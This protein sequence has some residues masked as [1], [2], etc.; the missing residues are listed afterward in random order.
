MGVIPACVLLL[1]V[2]GQL[3]VISE[4]MANPPIET[5]GEYV[6]IHNPSSFPC[7]VTGFSITDGDALDFLTAWDEAVHGQFP[8]TGAVTGTDTIPPFGYALLFELDYPDGQL[9]EI[10][11]GTIILTTGD[12]SICN[13][14]AA[15]SD[16]LTLFGA[17]GSSCSDVLS[18]YGTPVESD[19]WSERDDDGADDIP[20]DPGEGC[21]VERIHM[22]G[23]D[24]E[25]NWI[26]TG[27]GGTPGW[28]PDYPDT[29]DICVESLL[30]SPEHPLPGEACT[31]S[32]VVSNCGSVEVN[33]VE[34]TLFF[35]SNADSV[36]DPG[37]IIAWGVSGILEPGWQDTL[38]AVLTLDEGNYLL[39]AT[40][41]HPDDQVPYNDLLMQGLVC[42]TGFFPCISEVLC[43]PSDQDR[44]EFIELH[45][46]GPGVFDLSGCSFTDGDALDLV[47]AWN[48]ADPLQDPDAMYGCYMPSGSWALILDSEYT[49]GMQP[50]DLS[51]STLVLTTANTTLG[52]GL[53]SNDPITLYRPYG[54]VEA[55]IVS[56]YGTPVSSDDPLLCDDDGLDGI[57][58][59]PG[60]DNSVHRLDLPGPDIEEN[61]GDSPEGPTPGAPPPPIQAGADAAAALLSLSPPMGEAQTGVS[62][63]ATVAS[64]GTETIPAQSL[65]VVLWADLNCDATPDSPELILVHQ[66]AWELPPGD[67]LEIETVWESLADAV[68]IFALTQC[69]ADSCPGNDTLSTIWNIP[70]GAVINEIMY[71]PSPGQPEW[72][73]IRNGATW[74][75]DLQD[76]ILSDA[77]SCTAVSDTAA[78]LQ[79]GEF[80]VV[81]PD[82]SGFLSVWGDV[83]CLLCQPSSWPVLNNTTQPGEEYADLLSIESPGG[84]VMDFVPY[85]DDWGGGQNMSLERLGSDLPGYS[86]MSWAGSSPGGTP[87]AE[88]SVSSGSAEGGFLSFHPD[89]FS[90][91]GDG[92][93]DMLVIEMKSA[94]QQNSVTMI[95]Y[96]VNGRTVRRLLRDE[97][98]GS[99][100]TVIWDG[101]SDHGEALPVGRYIVYIR[102]EP[103]DGE[104]REDCAVVV[105]ARRL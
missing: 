77:S 63:V 104:L 15:S 40:V 32:A 69:T 13:G 55:D 62:I 17:S 83:G 65:T 52:D 31:L 101:C 18:T 21:S 57:P 96:D 34:T 74:Q 36:S 75:I 78:Q 70:P 53:T 105:L 92:V 50:W 56:T 39:A 20:F 4:S 71:H 48:T 11:D 33:G 95:V 7:P 41:S 35:D 23:P 19:D 37:E 100:C 12:H 29:C 103:S 30:T 43:N 82:T 87:G 80:A 9:L 81:C 89:P 16:P 5:T 54:T 88:N 47:V 93:D 73:E 14:L 42:G 84:Q 86:R 44:D 79:P 25:Q 91:D 99:T 72:I 1:Q 66:V 24:I 68:D 10:P 49:S 67:S 46:G 76:W 51:P 22:S 94:A 45:Y 90:P 102:A 98:A 27:S 8:H 97:P 64:C 61:W 38:T 58:Y 59:D 85:D 60:K 28:S 2:T 3:P 6:E 26:A